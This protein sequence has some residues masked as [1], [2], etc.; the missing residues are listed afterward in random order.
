MV[1]VELQNEKLSRI[2]SHFECHSFY[3]QNWLVE[4]SDHEYNF[5]CKKTIYPTPLQNEKV[6]KN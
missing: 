4:I 6:C 3:I 5:E 1:Q 2:E